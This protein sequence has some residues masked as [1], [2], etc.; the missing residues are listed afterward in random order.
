MIKRTY[1]IKRVLATKR[2]ICKAAAA[3]LDQRLAK[4]LFEGFVDVVRRKLP[5]GIIR[6][7]VRD[8][9]LNV[10][11]R[12]LT[13]E[14]LDDTA[15]RMAG[16]VPRLKALRTAPVWNRQVWD[17]YVPLQIVAVSRSYR[18]HKPMA[19]LTLRVLAG[20]PA[21][22]LIE[23]T[24][25]IGLCRALAQRLGF[26]SPFG[27][28]PFDDSRQLM[29]FRFYG[30][31][32]PRLC[33]PTPQFESLWCTDENDKI[34]PQSCYK[35]NRELL[36]CRNRPPGVFDCPRGFPVETVPCHRCWVGLDGCPVAV[37]SRSYTQGFCDGCGRQA[38]FD[39]SLRNTTVCLDCHDRHLRGAQ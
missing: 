25:S 20:T 38:L 31:I 19:S 26:T 36:R 24:W 39:P 13:Q 33:R 4:D 27:D 8:S 3:Y 17:E 14:L 6:E 22:L 1:S 5:A 11:G 35:H 12:Q 10:A 15:W 30:L 29:G 28:H 7:V 37:H 34:Y 32:E 2:T 21:G 16:N 9:L 18:H 23:T